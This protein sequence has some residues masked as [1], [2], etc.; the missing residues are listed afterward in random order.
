MPELPRVL[1]PAEPAGHT[2]DGLLVAAGTGDNAA[3]ALGLGIDAGDVVVSLGTS[4]T[5]FT[6]AL[7]PSADATG[8]STAFAD[9]AGAYLP[10]VC[11]LN[12]ARVLDRTAA[13][14]GVGLR[15]LETRARQSVPGAAGLTLL[16]YLAGERTPNLPDTTGTLHGLT[17]SNMTPEHLARAGIEGMLCNLAEAL[18]GSAPTASAR[19]E[20]CSSAARPPTAWSPKSPPRSSR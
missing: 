4:G 20:C 17:L 8:S 13:L 18:T 14:A 19:A 10:L 15:E 16:P 2:S 1:G 7:H 3:A 9:A 5:V 11:T 12:A 6:R